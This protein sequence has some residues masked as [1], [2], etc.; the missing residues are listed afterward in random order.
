MQSGTD[1][2]CFG[3]NPVCR[4]P[5]CLLGIASSQPSS[6]LRATQAAHKSQGTEAEAAD[7]TRRR[8]LRRPPPRAEARGSR[9]LERAAA[10]RRRT[11]G[12]GGGGGD[13]GGRGAGQIEEVS[14]LARL[15]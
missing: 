13:A 11:A 6:Q 7:Y 5:K 10:A 1:P 15:E 3:S 4:A 12:G 14:S 8:R 2:A 9:R